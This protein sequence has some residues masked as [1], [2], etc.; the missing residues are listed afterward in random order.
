M[1]NHKFSG[2]YDASFCSF[3]TYNLRQSE[4]NDVILYVMSMKG[5][6]RFVNFSL[7]INLSFTLQLVSLLGG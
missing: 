6:V 5:W 4:G 2:H 1:C 3:S 7:L